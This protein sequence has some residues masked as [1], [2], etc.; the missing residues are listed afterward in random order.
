MGCLGVLK[1]QSV[2]KDRELDFYLSLEEFPSHVTV[3][4]VDAFGEI[5]EDG[6]LLD[7]DKTTGHV[8]FNSG[9]NPDLGFDLD[10]DGELMM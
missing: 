3:V 4:A 6:F 10:G 9:I 7:I 1:R 5:L 8:T 2:S